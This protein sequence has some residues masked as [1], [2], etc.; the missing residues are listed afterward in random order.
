LHIER[1]D[2]QD[3]CEDLQD[4][5]VKMRTPHHPQDPPL[6]RCKIFTW[7]NNISY[8]SNIRGPRNKKFALAV[9]FYSV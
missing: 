1:D 5:Q 9:F 4:L 7:K 8:N 2:L 3:L 6:T